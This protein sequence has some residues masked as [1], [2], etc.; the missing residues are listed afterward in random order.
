MAAGQAE[1]RRGDPAR[2]P[3]TCGAARPCR[4]WP[5]WPSRRPTPG[6]LEEARLAALESR[7]DADLACGRH[8]SLVAELEGLAAGHPLRERLTG[9][10]ILA[11]YRCGRQA[12]AL[13]RLQRA[14]DRLPSEL[15]IDPSPE[16]R[17]LHERI[18]R[19]DPGLDW[20]PGRH[21][22][23]RHA[24]RG[25]PRRAAP[26][27][28]R[29][30][31]SALRRRQLERQ[32]GTARAGRRARRQAAPVRP[33]LPA[34]LP[35]E[36]TSFIGREAELDTIE[37]LLRLSRLVTLTGPGGCGKSRL[38]LR[39]GAQAAGRYAGG[40]WLV[41]LAPISQPDL[42]VPTVAQALSAREEPGQ[43]LL[44]SI[45]ARLRDSEALLIVDNCE[46]VSRR[47]RRHDRDAAA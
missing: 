8:A 31:R 15:G 20:H 22:A 23:R 5:R 18:L 37:E 30:P 14:R 47:R 35:T 42:V 12:D 29:P 19:Q 33:R 39:A 43:N 11:L 16:L 46:H 34:G 41:E 40:V 7:V 44:G 17:R 2:R 24:R 3:W 32:P 9:Q 25:R 6:R 36:T 28:H 26:W 27:R 21:A 13:T 1:G 45:V 10:R 38:A 4:T